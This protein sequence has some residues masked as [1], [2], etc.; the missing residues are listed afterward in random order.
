MS[1]RVR[2]KPPSSRNTGNSLITKSELKGCIGKMRHE[3]ERQAKR[4]IEQRCSY[5]EVQ[6]YTYRCKH[7]KGWHLTH[8]PPG[9][10]VGGRPNTDGFELEEFL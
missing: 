1:H 3:S 9:I 8:R 4:S 2:A 7:C 10:A 5:A 6:L